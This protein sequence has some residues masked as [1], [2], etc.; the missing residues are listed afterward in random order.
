MK[1]KLMSTQNLYMN[2]YSGFIHN[3]QNW[4]QPK[5]S[6]TDEWIDKPWS[7]HTTDGWTVVHPVPEQVL[8]PTVW[9][10]LKCNTLR[11]SSQT[12]MVTYSM[13]HMHGPIRITFRKMQN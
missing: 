7:I 11:E 12:Q 13:N 10:D 3:L 4:G 2:V 6:S 5:C 8:M 1:L 9:M